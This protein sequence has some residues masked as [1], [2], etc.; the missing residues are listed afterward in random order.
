M[1][2]EQ[3]LVPLV[4]CRPCPG[5]Q[6][7]QPAEIGPGAERPVSGA[8]DDRHTHLR[9]AGDGVPGV[10]EAAHEL[11]IQRVQLVRSVERDD[12]DAVLDREAERWSWGRW[13]V[14]HVVPPWSSNVGQVR[15]GHDVAEPLELP[16][17]GCRHAMSVEV[18]AV[19]PVTQT[20]P[21]AASIAV[22]LEGCGR[23]GVGFDG[24]WP[25]R[26]GAVR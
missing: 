5:E 14:G 24:W 15:C 25:C 20:V 18:P 16:G 17:P 3:A 2:G 23:I 4:G 12:G 13:C 19:Q 7:D 10:G 11:G 26:R 1:I 9:F 21:R 8:G 6:R 22:R